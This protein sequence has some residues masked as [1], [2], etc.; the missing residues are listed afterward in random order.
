MVTRRARPN[1][2]GGESQRR[3]LILAWQQPIYGYV[4]RMLG[5]ET[6]VA[7]L[8]Q[9]IFAK[10]LASEQSFDPERVRGW[11]YRI[12]TNVVYRH[13]RDSKL[14][15]EKERHVA[16][17]REAARSGNEAEL[18]RR[19]AQQV[20][21]EQLAELPDEARSLLVMHYYN[22]LSQR[23]IAG[24]LGIP[25][26]TV[27]DRLRK[28]LKQLRGRLAVVGLAALAPQ[29]EALMAS[30]PPVAVPAAVS[31][32]LLTL[33]GGGAG[34]AVSS[35]LALGGLAMTKQILLGAT[36]ITVV[37]LLAGLCI[38][39]FAFPA[40][41]SAN[42]ERIAAA[43]AELE[44]SRKREHALSSEIEDLEEQLRVAERARGELTESLEQARAEALAKQDSDPAPEAPEEEATDDFGI[45]W[46]ALAAAIADNRELFLLMAET[47]SSGGDLRDLTAEQQ[48]AIQ[49]LL[50]EWNKAAAQ[51]KVASAYPV[52][53]EAV[54]PNMLQS[55]VGGI[56]DLD[57][58]QLAELAAASVDL[59]SG[60]SIDDESL[61]TDAYG[62]RQELFASVSEV[63]D[64][65]LT[66]E[67]REQWQELA[68]IWSVVAE[69]NRRTVLLGLQRSDAIQDR[70]VR[71]WSTHFGLSAAQESTMGPMVGRFV[72]Q[73]REVLRASGQLGNDRTP[74]GD[75][76]AARLRE[77]FYQLQQRMEAQIFAQLSDEQRA[78][79]SGQIPVLFTFDDSGTVSINSED[80][81]GF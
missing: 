67:Q 42:E 16:M 30:A 3:E 6:D 72:E 22:G 75:D 60:Y 13:L 43:T 7:D 4:Y 2:R 74:L 48:A 51:A 41:G 18:E 25:R 45:D 61:P 71:E 47:I 5:R 64:G 40:G 21:Q 26:T 37:S 14:R 56:M 68:P 80:D 46:N 44:D 10:A 9:E 17:R 1:V 20:L 73:A 29:A 32:S 65:L 12:A 52:F 49:S 23:E 11:L 78:R 39:S 36:A 53:N 34:V 81:R 54:L 70:I 50:L 28:G 79:L 31:Q 8:T 59:L 63:V 24:V 15:R 33:A 57:D 69:G 35:N 76:G 55:F 66:P 19:E 62:A 38:G 58:E 77:Q 27:A